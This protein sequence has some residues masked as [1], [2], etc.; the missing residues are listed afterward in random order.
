MAGIGLKLDLHNHTHYSSDAVQSPAELLATAAARDIACIAVTDHN[1]VR[2]GVEA[3]ALAAAHP[4]LPRVIP[5]V[6]LATLS[7]EIIGLYVREEI[8]RS[9]PVEDAIMRIRAQGGIIYLPHPFDRVRR[10]AIQR[11]DRM[12]VAELSDIIEVMNGRSLGPAAGAKSAALAVRLGKAQGAGSD[13]HR[14]YEIGSTWVL[15]DDLP[16]KDTLVEL[17]AAGRVE[18]RL[19]SRDHVLNWGLMG[20]AP[21]TRFSRRVTETGNRMVGRI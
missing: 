19:R 9:L 5:G 2:G 4:H 15:V 21:V 7:G 11:R 18:H 16:T 12:R 10:G 17:V 14:T 13:A 1:T 3:A 8:P 20:L 6:E